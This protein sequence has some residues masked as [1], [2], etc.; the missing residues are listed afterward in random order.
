MMIHVI[1]EDLPASVDGW[2]GGNRPQSMA[3]VAYEL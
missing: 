1:E 2:Q 3:V